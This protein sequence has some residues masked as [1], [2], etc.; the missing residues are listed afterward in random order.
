MNPAPKIA[1]EGPP[2][3]RHANRVIAEMV[4]YVIRERAKDW[5]RMQDVMVRAKDGN[6]K[7][8]A[9]LVEKLKRTGGAGIN[10]IRLTSGKRGT[11]ALDI[12]D[13]TGWNPQTEKPIDVAEDIPP[14][15]DGLWLSCWVTCFTSVKG[16][17][18]ITNHPYLFITHHAL[19]RLAQRCGARTCHD[20]VNAVK[21][22]NVALYKHVAKTDGWST[23]P[24]DHRL[25][26]K[27]GV[28]VLM[29]YRSALMV[30][31]VIEPEPPHEAT[32]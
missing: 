27:H 28:M 15:T 5:E 23:L 21:W 14:G 11:Y 22:M 18:K 8:Q 4:R 2:P 1:S 31:T 6:P 29:P 3:E 13:W 25:P 20:L 30:V 10:N 9:R 26:F 32:C 12:F 24:K 19:S 7:A 16:N 17:R